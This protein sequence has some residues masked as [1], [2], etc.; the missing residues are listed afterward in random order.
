M[1]AY[2][3]FPDISLQGLGACIRG[4]FIVSDGEFRWEVKCGRE[5]GQ[6]H[7]QKKQPSLI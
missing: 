4:R 1:I 7:R 6:C 2:F 5:V 3:Y